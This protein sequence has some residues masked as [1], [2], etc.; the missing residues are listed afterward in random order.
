M[1]SY[2]GSAAEETDIASVRMEVQSLAL[3]SGLRI[4]HCHKLWSRSQMWH[5]SGVAV[6]VASA[7]S[8]SSY[9]TPSW[10]R[11]HAAGGSQTKTKQT[12]THNNNNNT[13]TDLNPVSARKEITPKNQW[14]GG[15]TLSP[16]ENCRPGQHLDFCHVRPWA[17]KPVTLLLDSNCERNL[18]CFHLLKLWSF[19]IPHKGKRIYPKLIYLPIY[20]ASR[21]RSNSSFGPPRGILELCG[22]SSFACHCFLF[23]LLIVCLLYPLAL[24]IHFFSSVFPF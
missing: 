24:F 2:C 16:Q 1:S 6:V 19:V 14:D 15:R 20:V 22:R 4:W 18:C 17:E 13:H 11:P 21:S 5:G 12:H 7:G 23:S 9:L 10:E 3:L 8:W